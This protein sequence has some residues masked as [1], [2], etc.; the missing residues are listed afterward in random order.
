[1]PDPELKRENAAL[2]HSAETQKADRQ[3]KILVSLPKWIAWAVI[4]WQ[5]RLSIEALTG[6]YAFP[7]L[8]TRSWRQASIWEVVCW[9]MAV[10]GLVFG[11]HYRYLVRKQLT[12]DLSRM[13][14]IE[15]R[16]DHVAA[17]SG[18]RPDADRGR[19]A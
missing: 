13:Q 7:S 8:L 11:I 12:R 2:D 1:M 19:R 15:K 9:T 18:N 10:L 16:L 6:K 3:G 5:I 17:D 14:S 4:A